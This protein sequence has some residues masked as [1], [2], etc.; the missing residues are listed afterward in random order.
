MSNAW[1][2]GFCLNDVI[3]S[4]NKGRGIFQQI[5]DRETVTQ[6]IYSKHGEVLHVEANLI[7]R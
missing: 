7:K 3:L 5:V 6:I 4:D 2:R 1:K